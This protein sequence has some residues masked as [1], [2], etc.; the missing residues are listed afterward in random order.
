MHFK[1][2]VA[3]LFL[4]NYF[5]GNCSIVGV[6]RSQPMLEKQLALCAVRIIEKYLPQN[7]PVI[8]QTPNIWKNSPVEIF[9]TS[10]DETEMFLKVMY[11]ALA[12]DFVI[13]GY[14]KDN[15]T[16]ETVL[17]FPVSIVM[18]ITED[19]YEH[20]VY[21]VSEYL[22]RIVPIASIRE[23]KII[24]ITTKI[25]ID[26]HIQLYMATIFL[27]LIWKALYASDTIFLIPDSRWRSEYE[28]EVPAVNVFGWTPEEQ[29][30]PC[31][32]ELNKVS[33]LDCWWSDE[34]GF[35]INQDLFPSKDITDMKG[36]T[37]VV[38]TFENPPFMIEDPLRKSVR[39][40]LYAKMIQ[41][42]AQASN[43]EVVYKEYD[44]GQIPDLS[45]PHVMKATRLPGTC[46]FS[47]PHFK[48]DVVWFVPAGAPFPTWYS[49]VK[50]F[51]P[52]MWFSVVATYILGCITYWGISKLELLV[53]DLKRELGLSLIFTNIFVSQLAGGFRYEFRNPSSLIFFPLW[54]IYCLQ[55]YTAYQ[56]SLIGFLANP[57][58]FPPIKS[59]DELFASDL[60]LNTAILWNTGSPI[61][62]IWDGFDSYPL[63][64]EDECFERIAEKRDLA[65]LTKRHY[66]ELYIT[67]H[68]MKNGKPTV[69]PLEEVRSTEY[70][71]L[72]INIGCY[73]Q[74]RMDSVF[75][76]LVGG[77]I[78]NKWS[79]DC[80]SRYIKEYRVKKENVDV[81]VL[82]MKH[83]KGVFLLLI[84]GNLVAFLCFMSELLLQLF[85]KLLFTYKWSP[86]FKKVWK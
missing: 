12:N 63:C 62:Q 85:H 11:E 79:E 83:L 7:A 6:D 73:M 25:P 55:I 52:T 72:Q 81:F 57:G 74:R 16:K 2:L 53:E 34:V 44:F 58:H 23:S 69:V 31:L 27:T 33:Q 22:K 50:I 1:H 35:L 36:C 40:G 45:G 49:L 47:Y 42:L 77:G 14:T 67:A 3:F 86:C 10:A 75:H 70:F 78:V 38:K 56:S 37:F 71:T 61:V 43:F 20:M 17:Q 9:K 41:A 15:E 60:E 32:K 24:I 80:K 46:G 54:L 68:H 82:T 84:I 59:T 18:L 30:D 48:D 66:S 29:N 64:M 5:S 8:I 51:H 39:E 65:L 19:E 28:T 26:D 4:Q 13:V 21:M 76:R